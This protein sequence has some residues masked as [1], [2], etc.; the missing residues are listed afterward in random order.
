MI[1]HYLPFGKHRGQPPRDVP[2]DYLGWLLRNCKLSSGLR[3]AIADELAGRGVAAP[4]IPAPTPKPPPHCRRCGGRELLVTWHE[5][6][7]GRRTI[8]GDCCACG[9]LVAFLP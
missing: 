5:I 8:R 7:G 9:R 3:N 2:A 4:A 1:E 6:R